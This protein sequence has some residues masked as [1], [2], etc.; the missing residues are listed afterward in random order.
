MRSPVRD[1]YQA[2]RTVLI[3]MRITLKYCFARTVTV[4]YP[5]RPPPVQPRYRGFHWFEIERC[6]ACKSCARACPVDCIYIEN[7]APRKVERETG[8]SRGGALTRW[9]VDY[10]KCM[11]CGLCCDPCPTECIKMGPLHDLS[12][13]QRIDAVVEFTELAKQ[14]LRTP[15]PLWMIK[16]PV[17][18]WA[19]NL[20]DEWAERAAPMR[21]EMALALTE[22]PVVKKP[23]PDGTPAPAAET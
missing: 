21:A 20:R 7:S 1:I 15:V 10:S 16:E 5:D 2:L 23:P 6:S 18:D 13:F 17:P 9:A 22:Q 12:G 3:G 8:I 4:Q 19:R 14:G 11:F